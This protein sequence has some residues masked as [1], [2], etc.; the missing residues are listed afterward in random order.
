[1]GLLYLYFY[2]Y[3]HCQYHSCLLHVLKRMDN[4]PIR[5]RNSTGTLP[6]P[7][8]RIN[9]SCTKIILEHRCADVLLE[10]SMCADMNTT[11]A[12]L[13]TRRIIDCSLISK[14]TCHVLGGEK[15]PESWA[16]CSQTKVTP[17]CTR[18]FY[19]PTL[20][21]QP[22]DISNFLGICFFSAC[23]TKYVNR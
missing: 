8:T 13:S 20:D 10:D 17:R 12:R 22:L 15:Q 23:V 7:I 9:F 11:D 18:Q 5:G 6:I 4:W 19:T 16:L 14:L 1:M 2:F 3:Y 21:K